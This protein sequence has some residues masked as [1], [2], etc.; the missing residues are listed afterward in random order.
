[1]NEFFTGSAV[2]SKSFLINT[3]FTYDK[4]NYWDDVYDNLYSRKWYN[5][6]VLV[7]CGIRNRDDSIP[8]QAVRSHKGIKLSIKGPKVAIRGHMIDAKYERGL[9]KVPNQEGWGWIGKWKLQTKR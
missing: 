3:I 7:G 2:I 5:V 1:M 4:I 9:K 8:Q 6:G